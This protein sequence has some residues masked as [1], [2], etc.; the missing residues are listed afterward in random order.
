MQSASNRD[1]Y[2]TVK[3]ENVQKGK[4]HNFNMYGTDF[5]TDFDIGYDLLS[6]MHYG[7]YDFSANQEPTIEPHVRYE[8]KQFFLF[9]SFLI[10]VLRRI[11]HI[12]N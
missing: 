9:N 8:S 4:E 6:I 2:I 12:K 10:F 5:V 1:D 7:A 3:W 11:L